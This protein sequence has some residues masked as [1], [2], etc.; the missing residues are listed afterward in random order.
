MAPPI[1]SCAAA[2]GGDIP[3]TIVKRP[4]AAMVDFIIVVSWCC[5]DPWIA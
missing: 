4:A 5:S 3:A 1:A 2:G